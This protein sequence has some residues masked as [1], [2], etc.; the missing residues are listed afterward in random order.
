[1]REFE[2]RVVRKIFGP[3][4]DDVTGEW[5]ELHNEEFIDPYSSPNIIIRLIK[6]KRMRWAGNVTRM[7]D[8]RGACRVSL[9]EMRKRDDLKDIDVDGRI[10]LKLILRIK[11]GGI[12]CI[13]IAQDRDKRRAVVNAV[14]NL[15]V[16]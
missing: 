16:P 15:Q 10:I 4:N 8:R 7:E 5:R 3:K 13:D 6:S 1:M 11:F 14:M 2:N 12:D 9:E